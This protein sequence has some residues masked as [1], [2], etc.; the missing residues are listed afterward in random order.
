MPSSPAD[1]HRAF[2]IERFQR[3]RGFGNPHLQTLLGRSLRPQPD[4]GLVRE[5]WETPDGDF[6]DLDFGPEPTP[7]APVVLLLHGLEGSTA[8]GYMRVAM[9]ELLQEGILPVGLNF[10]SCSGEPNRLPRFYHSGDTGDLAWVLGRL[11]ERYP[12]RPLGAIGFSLGGNVLLKYLGEVGRSS[13]VKGAVTLSVPF[14]LAEGVRALGQGLMGAIY[15]HYFLISLKR[16]A[17]LK[18]PTLG[19]HLD[20]HRVEAARSLEDFD[21]AFTAP[22]HGFPNAQ[23]YYHESSSAQFLPEIQTPTL[24]LQ[25]RDDPF[26]PAEALP[27]ARIRGNLWLL[28]GIQGFGGHVG[29]F[30]RSGRSGTSRFWG[31]R[32]AARYLSTILGSQR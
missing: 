10:R 32:E 25:S 21:D 13:L 1:L 6:L 15:T 17:R 14:D 11:G 26:L 2:Q 3:P 31:E 28:N 30:E 22:L 12:Q 19:E 4:P 16:K 23:T 29:F 9:V 18:G 27:E 20:L 8:R 7:E 24:L 5:R